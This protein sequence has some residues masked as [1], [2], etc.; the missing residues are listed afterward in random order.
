MSTIKVNSIK[1]TSTDDGG[2][3][4]DNSGHVQIDGQQLPT[5]GALSNRNLIINGAMQVAQR[6]TSFTSNGYTLDR[7]RFSTNAGAFTVTQSSTAPAGFTNSLKVDCTTTE[8]PTGQDEG[9]VETKIE[10][11]NLQHLQF[12]T[13]GAQPVTLS[14]HVKSNKTGSYGLWV[15]QEDAAS[16]YATTYTISS[17]D[18][19]E[20]KTITIP[21]NTATAINN[22][23]GMGLDFRFYL[24][25]GSDYAGTPAEAWTTTLTSNRTT[26][27]N[28]ADSTS[29]EWFI[30][31]VQLEV[32][33]KATPFE[34]RSYGDE[35]AKCMRYCQRY[36]DGTRIALGIWDN[37][38]SNDRVK[39]HHYLPVWMRATPAVTEVTNGNALV[40]GIAWY[41]VTGVTLQSESSNKV[42]IYNVVTNTTGAVSS[43]GQTPGAWGNGAKVT[44]DAE[45]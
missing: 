23:N 28:L 13:S 18:T 6:G 8:T 3:A 4:I 10:A 12:G 27:L 32:G 2:I 42:V 31:G 11:Q 17:A 30:T 34:H 45:L 41:T 19:W 35:L 1:N 39:A 33:E 29:N 38:S 7:W 44:L 22:D 36:G 40:E 43:S 25:A 24:L 16:Q 20:H 21:G 9:F 5:A 15:Y 37:V 26:S 14:F